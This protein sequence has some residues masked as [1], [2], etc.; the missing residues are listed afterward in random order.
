[1]VLLD[2]DQPDGEASGSG[3]LAARPTQQDTYGSKEEAKAKII[4]G[5][6]SFHLGVFNRSG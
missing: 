6:G 1:M 3:C 4:E 5:D 2:R